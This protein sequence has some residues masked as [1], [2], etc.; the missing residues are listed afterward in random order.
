MRENAVDALL[1]RAG[2][3]WPTVRRLVEQG[4]LAETVYRGRRY[5]GRKLNL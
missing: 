1:A 5:Y 4:R 2:V 3:G